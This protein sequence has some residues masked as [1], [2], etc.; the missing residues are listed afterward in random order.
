METNE[1]ILR[2]VHLFAFIRVFHLVALAIL[3]L[4]L[5][6]KLSPFFILFSL[7]ASAAAWYRFMLIRSFKY[8]IEPEFIRVTNGIFFKT[9]KQVE[10]FRVKDYTVTQPFL[11]QMFKMMDL[12]L[13]TT[14]PENAIVLL[15]G[16]PQ[17]DIVDVLRGRV[18]E[19]RQNNKIYEIN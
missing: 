14:D 7:A 19:A 6:W 18:Q 3:F 8:M 13:K 15:R 11:H 1:I 17:S 16:I 2:P 12:T 5:A 9:T 4:L 10:L